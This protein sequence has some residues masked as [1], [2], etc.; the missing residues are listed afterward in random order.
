MANNSTPDVFLLLG[1]EGGGNIGKGSGQLIA[2]QLKQIMHDVEETITSH[3]KI[4]LDQDSLSELKSQIEN[5][6]AEARAS[7]KS[8]PLEFEFSFDQKSIDKAFRDVKQQLKEQHITISAQQQD[9]KPKQG[10]SGDIG[11]T[12]GSPS[13]EN[14][15][16]EAEG[17][18]QDIKET[19]QSAEKLN[20]ELDESVKKIE[21]VTSDIADNTQEALEAEHQI[22]SEKIKQKE[23]S[24]SQTTM[25]EEQ[26]LA[27]EK[28]ITL[29]REKQAFYESE[30]SAINPKGH[31]QRNQTPTAE[32]SSRYDELVN[33]Y[34]RT[35]RINVFNGQSELD[36]FN[37]LIFKMLGIDPD[38]NP[39]AVTDY[40]AT[41][42]MVD[43]T[44]DKLSGIT[45]ATATVYAN[46]LKSA[47][48]QIAKSLKWTWV[49]EILR[50]L[51][52]NGDNYGIFDDSDDSLGG[53][54]TTPFDHI[55]FHTS[56][57]ADDIFSK[58]FTE[59][60]EW[61]IA[62]YEFTEE[63]ANYY[64]AIEDI[65]DQLKPLEEKLSHVRAFNS[66]SREKFGS[67]IGSK[68]LFSQ[69][70]SDNNYAIK[71]GLY[72]RRSDG[73]V[74]LASPN[75][76]A[77]QPEMW[78]QYRDELLSYADYL[79][80]YR[81]YIFDYAARIKSDAIKAFQ[82]TGDTH[83]YQEVLDSHRE[84]L[85]SL[86]NDYISEWSRYYEA[87][88]KGTFA[89]DSF[90]LHTQFEELVKEAKSASNVVEQEFD[91]ITAAEDKAV[92]GADDLKYELS[93]FTESKFLEAP[94]KAAN[95]A[96][97]TQL[98]PDDVSAFMGSDTQTLPN[99]EEALSVIR[100]IN[101]ERERAY[102]MRYFPADVSAFM[103]SDAQDLDDAEEALN[104]IRQIR[105]AREAAARAAA[106]E[107][108]T[109]RQS[110]E[111]S[112]DEID[113]IHRR[114]DAIEDET[115]A[116]R[117]N[118]RA[119]EEIEQELGDARR[120]GLDYERTVLSHSSTY[121]PN[122]VTHSVTTRG[123]DTGSVYTDITKRVIG[124]DGSEQVLTTLK[125][126]D[127]QINKTIENL[128][129]KITILREQMGR[130][131]EE[132]TGEI[133]AALDST[134]QLVAAMSEAA[135]GE[136]DKMNGM[137]FTDIREAEAEAE[138]SLRSINVQ[139]GDAKKKVAEVRKEATSAEKAEARALAKVD[140]TL[141]R[142]DAKRIQI[143]RELAEMTSEYA[144]QF[145][146][147]GDQQEGINKHIK[148]LEQLKLTIEEYIGRLREGE[149]VSDFW[150]DRIPG[151]TNLDSAVKKLNKTLA[152]TESE[153]AVLKGDSTAVTDEAA[154]VA[155]NQYNKAIKDFN[156][157]QGHERFEN[158][159]GLSEIDA[160]NLEEVRRNYSAITSA[161]R[162]LTTATSQ[163]N[164][165]Y[166]D[167][168]N[169]LTQRNKIFQEAKNY[170]DKY[171]SGIKANIELNQR[172]LK[173]MQQVHDG[174]I[175]NEEARRA[176][177]ELQTATKDANAETM[178]LWGSLKKLFTDHFGSV[179]ATA[180]IGVFR[181]ILRGAYQNVLDIDKAMTELKKVTDL[182]ES[183]YVSFQNRAADMAREVGGT[184]ADTIRSTA[185]YARLGFGLS[186]SEALAKA[187]LVYKNVG[188]GLESIDEAS[189]SIISTIKAFSDIDASDAM[190]IIDKFNEVGNNFAVSS[191][192]IGTSLK[193]SAA[194]LAAAN[195]TIDESIAL[196]TAANSVIQNP[197]VVGT[198]AKTIS[199]FL[200]ASK[201]EAEEA[202]IETEG[203]AESVSKLREE[204]LSLSKV[205]IMLDDKNYKSTY[206][207]LKE[208]SEVWDDISDV[209]Q[210]NIL[211]KLGGKRN[212]NV[213]A[214]IIENFDVA[215]EALKTS[216][217]SEGSALKENE[218]Y[219]KSIEGHI[220]KLKVAYEDLS[221]AVID[222]D[223]VK[224]GVDSL[225]LL[226]SGAADL[227]KQFGTLQTIIPIIAGGLSAFKNVGRDKALSLTEYADCGVVVTRNELMAA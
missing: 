135:A 114:T 139:L 174:E 216:L 79:D 44:V 197:E 85:E 78:S 125:S 51:S 206:Q 11:S 217:D 154:R 29:E 138:R 104:Y 131:P 175:N 57:E 52:E 35:K 95:A 30:K 224:I 166:R 100:Q 99:A 64:Q 212:A 97:L 69:Y 54:T 143:T 31:R 62:V 183:Q 188:D 2:T 91:D 53:I 123:A 159:T 165:E 149:D 199:M 88:S 86:V 70:E 132:Y 208:I 116:L 15:K 17:V 225:T 222:S 177:A 3:L 33:L 171:Q 227:I 9:K 109:I 103:G 27:I 176:L 38:E 193:K 128:S 201:T 218:K 49:Q 200:R 83:A 101:E 205:D 60:Q 45:E 111:A 214:S 157:A 8:E 21:D 179:S 170:Y 186:D 194:A 42:K 76:F 172:W 173:L 192:G 185:D 148:S 4:K 147:A 178:T 190:S 187:A 98:F 7:I 43:I 155:V 77:R 189:E 202:G 207:I 93:T 162:D 145:N 28:Q 151:V 61:E 56:A 47:L 36:E 184:I 160:S 16:K 126:T 223:L 144:T 196:L 87:I 191:A 25:S 81:N 40:K 12:S 110:S 141:A 136:P 127:A 14:T 226:T 90:P 19:A 1:V 107:A 39:Q 142:A 18:K 66:K 74:V 58:V 84:H 198:T 32:V 80:Q 117:E 102:R 105:E 221:Q 34:S 122:G 121:A 156:S 150:K 41:Q 75:T 140:E 213:V 67:K 119:R 204:I 59:K 112:E 164:S 220:N 82:D 133:K 48:N 152:L 65:T 20:R 130:I 163:L 71:Q 209:S 219:L 115:D 50:N 26:R 137:N 182:A 89:P 73:R 181:N 96:N 10:G 210:A 37:E 46:S 211:E 129:K 6:I 203:M 63:A 72:T 23:I 13:L 134:E 68:S 168:Q 167:E 153:L 22:T 146:Y 120:D 124:K 161:T 215:E 158:L 5:A 92:K 55:R 169:N 118:S 106:E 24:E 180:A 195:N 108:E 94:Q 113:D